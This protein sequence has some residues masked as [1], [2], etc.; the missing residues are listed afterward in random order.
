MNKILCDVQFSS[1][2]FIL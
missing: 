1:V 2:Q